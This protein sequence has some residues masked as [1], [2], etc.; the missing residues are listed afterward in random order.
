MEHG[1]VMSTDSKHRIRTHW[2][3][4]LTVTVGCVA[5]WSA[6]PFATA[7]E[8]ELP[9]FV[10]SL[11]VSTMQPEFILKSVRVRPDQPIPVLHRKP[12][13]I[14]AWV[15]FEEE[16][17]PSPRSPS[18]VKRQIETAK[19]GLDVSVFA[20]DRF[21]KSIR[22]HADFEFDQGSFRR[23]RTNSR[24]RFSDN[25]RVKLDID[26]THGRPYLGARVVVPFGN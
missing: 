26:L 24:G 18:P 11:S 9:V 21:V 14:D 5:G 4:A 23:T 20:V 13:D 16:Y 22:D 6:V 1:F 15:K 3:A 17:R 12:T 7:Q 2:R 19:Y 8:S 10:A 25:P